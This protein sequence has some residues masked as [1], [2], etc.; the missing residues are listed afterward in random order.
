MN[1]WLR[2][3]G[4]LVA[5]RKGPRIALPE[6]TARITMRV[7]P[8]D[9]DLNFHLT[10]SRYLALMDLARVDMLARAGH[11]RVLLKARW[12]PVVTGVTIRYRRSL[13]PFQ[14][15]HLETRLTGWDEHFLFLEQRFL[16]ASGPGAGELAASAEVRAAFVEKGS[17]PRKVEVAQ[18]FRVLGITA[19]PL[20]AD[21]PERADSRPDHPD[22]A[23]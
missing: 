21:A 12:M 6:E 5:A 10:N 23:S 20:A 17:P 3:I 11:L 4:V 13:A 1:L 14:K 19:R 18:L 16:I 2:L 7:W 22:V 9:L 15:F 8:N